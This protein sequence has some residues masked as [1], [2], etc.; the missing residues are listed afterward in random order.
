MKTIISPVKNWRD[1]LRLL[2]GDII[3]TIDHDRVNADGYDSDSEK[4]LD[5]SFPTAESYVVPI[6]GKL[7]KIEILVT[8]DDELPYALQFTDNYKNSNGFKGT[9]PELL[10]LAR[11][12][13]ELDN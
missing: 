9:L 3:K 7:H 1:T 5:F 13:G 6:D 4:N 8:I 11:I 12:G 10:E 2:V